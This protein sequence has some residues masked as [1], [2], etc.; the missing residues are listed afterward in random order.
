MKALAPTL[1]RVIGIIITLLLVLPA[2][3]MAQEAGDFAQEYKFSKEELT[4]ML[5]PIALYPDAL[6]AQIL[7]A[8]TYPLEVVEAE[9]WR[10]QNLQLKGNDLDNALLDKEWEPSV[11]SLCHFPD[12]L[13][14]DE[15]QARPDPEARRCLPR[16]GRGGHGHGAGIAQKGHGAGQSQGDQRTEG[17]R[18]ER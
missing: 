1:G 4:Q 7:M 8:S 6:T 5:A 14:V 11:K 17:E 2:G 9:R 12:I 3:I 18:R 13:K 16:P 10:S 15:R